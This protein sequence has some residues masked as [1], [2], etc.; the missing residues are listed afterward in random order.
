MPRSHTGLVSAAVALALAGCGSSAATTSSQKASAAAPS[1]AAAAQA[2]QANTT[3]ATTTTTRA[4]KP[5]TTKPTKAKAVE[6]K[7]AKAKAAPNHP[8]VSPVKAASK[9]KVVAKKPKP[10]P[11][12]PSAT[13]L[14]VGT[15]KLNVGTVLV[16]A[17]GKTLYTFAPDK[18]SKPT[19]TGSCAAVWPPLM[20]SSTEKPTGTGGVKQSL[21]G[22]DPYPGGGSIVTYDG[23]PLYTFSGDSGPGSDNGQGL[24][25]NGGAW[26]VISP[27]GARITKR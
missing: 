25:A 4:G 9:P 11:A 17:A 27:A 6:H 16:D 5:K 13:P 21:L 2:S 15:R 1:S 19:C 24:V 3:A 7:T 14:D 8:K 10:K 23:W 20:V 26:Y 22:S 18:H 12:A